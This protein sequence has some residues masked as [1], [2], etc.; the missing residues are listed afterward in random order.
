M[1]GSPDWRSFAAEAS[2]RLS[3]ESAV[4]NDFGAR[5]MKFFVSDSPSEVARK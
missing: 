3:Q 2:R 5:R 4:E 1:V